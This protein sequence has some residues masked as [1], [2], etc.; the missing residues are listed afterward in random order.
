MRLIGVRTFKTNA[1]AMHSNAIFM[2]R[3]LAAIVPIGTMQ[4]AFIVNETTNKQ[5]QFN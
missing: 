1:F 5:I 4:F 3:K 2:L